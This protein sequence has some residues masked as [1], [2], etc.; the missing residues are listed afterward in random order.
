MRSPHTDDARGRRGRRRELPG[1]LR[2]YAAGAPTR[3]R[4]TPP[5]P[6]NR[7]SRSTLRDDRPSRD[8]ARTT[9]TP[10]PTPLP[11]SSSAAAASAAPRSVR[12]RGRRRRG[13]DS[14]GRRRSILLQDQEEGQGNEVHECVQRRKGSQWCPS[15]RRR[16]A[17]GVADGHSRPALWNSRDGAPRRP[18]RRRSICADAYREDTLA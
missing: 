2:V 11:P 4:A 1:P 13:S 9:T 8:D 17:D 10:P 7:G 3:P 15:G 12:D 14:G 18:R 16:H 5:P 6:F